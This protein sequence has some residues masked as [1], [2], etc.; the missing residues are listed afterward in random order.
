MTKIWGTKVLGTSNM[1]HSLVNIETPTNDLKKANM[2]NDR[3]VK[4]DNTYLVL[5]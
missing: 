4:E 2:V 1:F 5:Y 3:L